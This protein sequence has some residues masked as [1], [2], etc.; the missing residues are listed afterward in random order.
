MAAGPRTERRGNS[1][2]VSEIRNGSGQESAALA[3]LP[4]PE[5]TRIDEIKQSEKDE[6]ASIPSKR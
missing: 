1:K 3:A 5:L 6:G 4:C 2:T